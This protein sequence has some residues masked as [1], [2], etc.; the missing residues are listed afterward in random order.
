MIYNNF[1]L[2]VERSYETNKYI[3]FIPN[4][5][6]SIL[7]YS[8]K[9]AET[10]CH[11]KASLLVSMSIQIEHDRAVQTH[12]TDLNA[13]Q[14]NIWTGLNDQQHEGCFRFSDGTCFGYKHWEL[15][16]PKSNGDTLNCVL[17][18]GNGK[19]VDADCE[20]SH[21][22]LCKK[23]SEQLLLSI[24]TIVIDVEFINY[25]SRKNKCYKWP[26]IL[27]FS[28]KFDVHYLEWFLSGLRNTICKAWDAKF[29]ML[30]FF[31]LAQTLML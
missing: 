17:L 3:Y 30:I 31:C 29:C 20:E 21:A 11:S 7:R 10:Y 2:Y 26:Q 5:G 14:L 13:R 12:R 8:W 22:F 28:L 15:N 1:D 23:K 16:S 27:S 25:K 4:E 9:N 24:F 18:N 6:G 19:L